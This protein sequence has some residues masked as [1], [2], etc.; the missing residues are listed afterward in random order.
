[1]ISDRYYIYCT[2]DPPR[3]VYSMVVVLIV[4]KTLVTDA[5]NHTVPDT[6]GSLTTIPFDLVEVIRH[7]SLALT[8][9]ATRMY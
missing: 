3:Q 7:F 2:P 8:S 9:N 1:M 6:K 4:T 5:W